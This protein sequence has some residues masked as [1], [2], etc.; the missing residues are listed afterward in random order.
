MV[1]TKQM[2]NDSKSKYF[3]IEDV[4]SDKVFLDYSDSMIRPFEKVIAKS[5]DKDK[6]LNIYKSKN[7]IDLTKQKTLGGNQ[8]KNSAEK[9]MLY[10][11]SVPHKFPPHLYE[12]RDR[13]DFREKIFN[14]QFNDASSQKTEYDS[15][16]FDEAEDYFGHDYHTFL[17]IETK[18]DYYYAKRYSGHQWP[19]V[20]SL[21]GL[22]DYK[23]LSGHKS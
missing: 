14:A 10:Y 23:R 8:L 16:G 7:I 13:E 20:V 11:I 2:L 5:N 15:F 12:Y 22:I 18:E 21:L 3:V 9:K 4:R 6:L 1:T 19:A 17:R